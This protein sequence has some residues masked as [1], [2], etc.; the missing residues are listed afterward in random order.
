MRKIIIVALVV[1]AQIA[2]GQDFKSLASTPPMGWNSWNSFGKDINEQMVKEVIDA[3]VNEG[4]LDAGYIYVVIDGGWR[5]TKLG[6]NGELLPH[7]VKFPH[8]IKPLADY[9]HSRGLKFGL[10]TVPGTLDCGGDSVGGY[11]HEEIQLQQFVDWGVDLIK[12]DKCKFDN[13]FKWDEEVLKE[14]YFKWSKLI[15]NSGRDIVFSISAYK[16]RDWYQGICHMARTTLDI[17]ATVYG[18]AVFDSEAT[19][20]G[21]KSVMAIAEENNMAASFAGNGYWNDP[22]MLVTG[23]KGIT[24][25]EQKAHFALW[26]IMSAPLMLGNDPRIMEQDEKD[27]ILNEECIAIDQ[28]ATEQGKR[29][30]VDGDREIWAKKLQDGDVA[31][32][33]LNR[34]KQNKQAIDLKFEDVGIDKKVKIR[35]VFDKKD[36]GRFSKSFSRVVEAGTGSFLIISPR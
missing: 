26:C 31:V 9:A 28:D 18:K 34:N 14:T 25:E 22:D 2:M 33:L 36:L 10:H 15:K 16:Y 12:L 1:F 3:I 30:R 4:L 11:G 29:I 6:T 19:D 13:T 27:I 20:K 21:F 35:D 24:N 8:G 5:D 17:D 32:L 23:N 7:P